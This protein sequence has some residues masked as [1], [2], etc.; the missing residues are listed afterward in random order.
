MRIYDFT[1]EDNE[2]DK[3]SSDE[4]ES[5]A[6][7]KDEIKRLKELYHGDMQVTET[8]AYNVDKNGNYIFVG[9]WDA[10]HSPFIV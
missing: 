1:Y 7:A 9:R 10:L 3:F 8:W 2:G 5:L 4:Y 6:E